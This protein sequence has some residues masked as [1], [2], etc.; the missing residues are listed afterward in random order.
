MEHKP[1]VN[2]KTPFLKKDETTEIPTHQTKRD[3]EKLATSH[4][5]TSPNRGCHILLFIINFHKNIF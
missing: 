2:V 1:K 4:K 5:L 3:S